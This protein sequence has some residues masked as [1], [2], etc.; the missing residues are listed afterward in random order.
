MEKL[1]IKCPACG[2]VMSIDDNPAFVG[3]VVTCP[4]CKTKR[5]FEEYKR[6][7]PPVMV[8][9]ISDET[10]VVNDINNQTC[11]LL[12]LSSGKKYELKEGNNI[13]GRKTYKSPSKATVPIETEDK[14]LS[15]V[16]CNINVM[17][18]NDGFFHTYIS[19]AE[20]KNPTYIN[21][22]YLKNDDE[23][24][25]KNGDVIK[26]SETQLKFMC[27]STVMSKSDDSDKTML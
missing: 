5:K 6:S 10:V 1:I 24:A 16:H 21:S 9:T 3:R 7:E 13:I 22:S 25:L 8:Q 4:V 18:G 27:G 14:G 11:A 12:D 23:I 19:N 26:S 17:R 2:Q 20:N 15:R